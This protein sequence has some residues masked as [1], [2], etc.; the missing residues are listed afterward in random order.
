MPVPASQG[1]IADMSGR[2]TP[3]E[4]EQ[5]STQ[6]VSWKAKLAPNFSR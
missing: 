5:I 1:F 3:A 2:L 6:R 4:R